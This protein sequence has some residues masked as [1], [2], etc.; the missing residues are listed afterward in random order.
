[1]SG[2]QSGDELLRARLV[3]VLAHTRRTLIAVCVISAILN[4]LL[5]GGSIYMM[6]VYDFVLPSQSIPTLVG[7][8]IMVTVIY[9]VQGLLDFIRGR[10]LMHFGAALDTDLSPDVH[11][12][13][14]MLS[15]TQMDGD[16]L[17]PIRDLDQLRG[18]LSGPGP[19]TLADLPWMFLFIGFL[20]L[21][22]PYLGL[23]VLVGGV[24]LI[25]MTYLTERLTVE[26]S[27]QVMA[28]GQRRLKIA[29]VTRRHSEAIVANGMEQRICAS[30]SDASR[31]YLAAQEQLT[32]VASRM[33]SLTRMLRLLLQSGVLTVG[34]LLVIEHA[35]T[36]GVIFASSI[37]SARALAPVEAA[38]AN[39]RGFVGARQSW[40]RLK[41]MVALLPEEPSTDILPAPYQTLR[42]EDVSVSP[43]GSDRKTVVKV[44]F[45]CEAGS[46]IAVIG[47]SGS[48]KS[49]LARAL[50][51]IWPV[52][53]GSIKLDGADLSQWNSGALGLQVGYVPQSVELIEGTIAQN[54]ARFDPQADVEAIVAA[55][56]E[57]GVHD[58]ILNLPQG[59]NSQVGP[60]GHAL[61]GG[62][63]QRIA[64][65]RALYGNPFLI[66]LDEPNANLDGEG[67]EALSRA[68]MSARARG[69]IVITIAHRPSV[70][71]AVDRILVM[72]DGQSI[73][74]GPRN[75]ILAHL[76]SPTASSGVIKVEG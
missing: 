66:V 23:T 14:S 71:S 38:I 50:V 53:G 5:L 17:Q 28:V 65:A 29:D 67:D 54:I 44:N 68:I 55:A 39:W 46:A 61:S 69:A 60:D 15:R 43:P 2:P 74:Y 32:N 72:R 3:R 73:G 64:L 49:S 31:A 30:W 10:L 52:S 36:G 4:V 58:M 63:R 13:V 62:Q 57:A 33:G 35:A 8:A 70:L 48:G 40:S 12:M 41:A 59:Y 56:R 24:I 1:M 20:F 16:P 22:H 45:G 7:L 37:M 9:A 42:A 18:F 27:K 6:L 21:L 47:P 26:K 11:K 51:G 76:N 75:A 25:I 34:A 19:A